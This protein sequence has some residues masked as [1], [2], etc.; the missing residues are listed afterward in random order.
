[1]AWQKK[2]PAKGG[3]VVKRKQAD[4]SIKSYHYPAYKPL[5]RA[6]GDTIEALIEAYRR[7]PE[8][9]ALSPK[10]HAVR[11]TYFRVFDGGNLTVAIVKRRDI[12]ALRDAVIA[13]HGRGAANGFLAASSALF[14]WAVDR[15]WIDHSPVFKIPLSP[16]GHLRPWTR[17]EADAA[18]RGLPEH[19]RRCVV[20]ARHTGQRRG[21]LIAM[22]WDAY[23]GQSLRVVQQKNKPGLKPVSLVIPCNATLREELD[24]WKKSATSVTILATSKGQP[25]KAAGLSKYLPIALAAIG[26]SSELGIHGLRKLAATE[27]ADAGCSPHEIAS[28]TGHRTL[29][30]IEL[31]T[32]SADQERLA[33]AAVIRLAASRKK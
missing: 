25:W 17:Q 13:G 29:Q 12:M 11:I 9:A 3:R 15:E 23:D 6:N 27:L 2:S 24:W 30:M 7:S 22:R 8:W 33:N 16:S 10:T 18:N 4:G 1:M 32:K 26:L 19:L 21:D 31:Y 14:R 28:I 20:L 5:P